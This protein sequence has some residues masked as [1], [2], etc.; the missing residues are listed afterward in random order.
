MCTHA[1]TSEFVTIYLPEYRYACS[2]KWDEKS[3]VQ[4][5]LLIFWLKVEIQTPKPLISSGGRSSL[6]LDY[7]IHNHRLHPLLAC[8][9][10][11]FKVV[12]IITPLLT[13][14]DLDCC[15]VHGE[16]EHQDLFFL[17]LILLFLFSGS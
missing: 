7:S 9:Y 4:L 6:S 16:L 2:S 1:Q 14:E 12:I 13:R 15:T 3:D 11:I 8:S 10:I 5:I 17:V